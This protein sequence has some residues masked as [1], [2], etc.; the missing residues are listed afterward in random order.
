MK[1]KINWQIRFQNPL[2]IAQLLMAIIVPLIGYVGITIQ[3]ITTWG[4]LFD[5][6]YQAVM[7]PY[8]LGLIVVSVYNTVIDPTTKGM[9][10]SDR[11]LNKE[12]L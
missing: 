4:K 7:N 3:D 10:D 5:V 12:K 9:S 8:C 1:K 11:V 6:L 2:F